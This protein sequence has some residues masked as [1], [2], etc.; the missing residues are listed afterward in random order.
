MYVFH[1]QNTHEHI[2]FISRTTANIFQKRTPINSHCGYSCSN[3]FPGPLTY[4]CYSQ[5]PTFQRLFSSHTSFF[6]S[7]TSPSIPRL[8][9]PSKLHIEQFPFLFAK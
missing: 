2:L 4:H 8:M 9:I 5:N 7:N 1:V 3:I 6:S